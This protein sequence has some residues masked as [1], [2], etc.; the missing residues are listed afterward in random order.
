[1]NLKYI[2]KFCKTCLYKDINPIPISFNKEGI[3]TGCIYSIKKS[4]V[5]WKQ[6]EINFINL[7]KEYKN[8]Y[9]YDCILPV[10]GGKD[11]YFAAHIAKKYNLKA[12]MVTYYS[13]RYLEEGKYNLF[14]MK[15]LFGFD[16]IIFTPPE[17]VLIKMHRIGLKKMGDQNMHNHIGIDTYPNIIAVQKKVPLIIWGEQGFTEMGGMHSINDYVEYTKKY[18]LEHAQHGYDW[19]D[20]LNIEDE[21]LIEKD[22]ECYKYP[23]ENLTK[24]I[25]LRGIYLSNYFFYDGNYN[26]KLSKEN[27]NWKEKENGFDRTYRSFSNVDDMHENGVHDYLKFIKFGYGRGTDHAN[28]DVRLNKIS[29]AEGIRL[30]LKYDHITPEDDLNNWCKYV[31]MEKDEFY[32]HADKFRDPRIWTKKNGYWYKTDIDGEIRKYHKISD[33]KKFHNLKNYADIKQ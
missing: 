10:G 24:E 23:E 22:I 4:K 20:F 21:Y 15:E 25:N 11:S 18:R 9:E 31:G 7:I 5:D 12:L 1:M 19:Y 6:R 29:R 8:K 16:H 33:G 27:Y 14:R 28:Y 13:N 2:I 30:V 26:Y 3:C 17:E 32:F